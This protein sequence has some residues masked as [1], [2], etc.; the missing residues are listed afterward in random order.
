MTSRDAEIALVRIAESLENIELA[1]EKIEENT[2]PPKP[3]TNGEGEQLF[4]IHSFYYTRLTE[5]VDS[6]LN[7]FEK[8]KEWRAL[9]NESLKALE[10]LA[11]A[12]TL[13]VNEATGELV[14]LKEK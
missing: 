3:V 12:Q 8:A 14:K 6:S 4:S 2:A 5:I 9:I 10:A 13:M 11:P 1:L 7:N